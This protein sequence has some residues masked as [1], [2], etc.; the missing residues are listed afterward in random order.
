MPAT[1]APEDSGASARPAAKMIRL[2]LPTASTGSSCR[3]ATGVAA[4][5]RR[6][7]CAT[8]ASAIAT[9]T[10]ASSSSS[11]V[12]SAAC[13]STRA[14]LRGWSLSQR[15]SGSTSTATAWSTSTFA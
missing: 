1:A 13:D 4:L 9:A 6:E 8:T 10:P 3:R 12:A 7:I 11:T 14:R 5:A 15:V 2:S